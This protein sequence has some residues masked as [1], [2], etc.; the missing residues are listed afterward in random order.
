MPDQGVTWDQL[1]ELERRKAIAEAKEQAKTEAEVSGKTNAWAKMLEEDNQEQSEKIR[2]LESQLASQAEET[3]RQ[4]S[5]AENYRFALEQRKK[6]HVEND[7]TTPS[8]YLPP[9]TVAQAVENA[10][11][12]HHEKLVFSWNNKGKPADCP[13]RFPDEV[14]RA[15]NWLATTYWLA[16]TG[17]HPC[18]DLD[19][20][21]RELIPGWSF[22]G[23]QKKHSVGKH[24]SWYQC[25]WNRKDYWIGEHLGCGTSKRP[26]ETIRI[27]F[28]WDDEQK[29]IVIGFIGQHQRNS[30][31]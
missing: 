13:Y 27:A 15:F 9:D 12:D 22:S 11:R 7:Q 24:E 18:A 25:T 8:Q 5:L 23:G 1:L 28:A 19:K 26:E 30:N 17:K 16:R 29:K 4:R 2:L 20:S 31:T 21:V 10:E 6:G 14:E 3:E